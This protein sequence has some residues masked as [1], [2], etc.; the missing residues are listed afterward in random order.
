LAIAAARVG[1]SSGS[2]W[3]T[4][5]SQG[6]A[7]VIAKADMDIVNGFERIFN[8]RVFQLGVLS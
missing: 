6:R 4:R 8:A 3:G 1:D 2:F 7:T 5:E